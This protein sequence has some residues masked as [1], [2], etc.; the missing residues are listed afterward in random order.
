MT[1][2]AAQAA[3]GS[4]GRIGFAPILRQATVTSKLEAQV[5]RSIA[6]R[7]CDR[8]HA[9]VAEH[10]RREIRR[11]EDFRE[12][13]IANAQPTGIGAEGGHDGALAVTG[14]APPLHR[15]SARRHTRLGMKMARDFTGSTGRLVTESDRPDRD[16]GRD[17]AA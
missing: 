1:R 11:A 15:T 2:S 13:L 3:S 12:G 5:R 4:P 10:M 14:K 6:P 8:V 16:F 9:V 17:H 7:G